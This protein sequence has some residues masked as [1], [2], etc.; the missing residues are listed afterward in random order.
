MQ[1]MVTFSIS[2]ENIK[3]TLARFQEGNATPPAGVNL[4]GRW[5]AMGT[6]RG[7]A[8]FDVDDPV[9]FAGFFMGWSDL[10]NQEVVPVVEDDAIAASL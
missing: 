6:G 2:P 4:M 7:F 5:H 10:A 3:A 8:L 9:A 1:C